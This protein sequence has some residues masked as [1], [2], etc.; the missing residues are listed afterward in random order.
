LQ[1]N[2]T[3]G[4]HA[5]RHQQESSMNFRSDINGLRA[6]AVLAVILFHFNPAWLPGGFAGVDVFFVISGYLMTAIIY[7]GLEQRNL[8]ILQFYLARGKRIIPALL[9]P[10]L[11]L[12]GLG[13]LFLLP[14][15]YLAVGKHVAA[16]LTFISNM[17]YWQESSYF[18]AASHEKWLLHTWSLSVEWQFYM[19]Y[20]VVMALLARLLGMKSL[21]WLLLAGAVLGYGGALYA[22][23]RWPD[24]AFFLL[25][26]RAWE[27]MLGGV[28]LLFPL[29]LTAGRRRALELGGA[30]LIAVSY[31]ACSESDAWPG[32]MALMPVLGAYALIAANRQESA[33]TGNRFAQWVGNI[34]YSLY[35]WHWPVVVLFSYLGLIGEPP[36]QLLGIAVSL[37]L[38]QA[39]YQLVEQ[40]MKAYRGGSGMR[41]WLSGSGALAGAA[42]VV[43]LLHGVVTP[44][45][46]ISVSDKAGFVARYEADHVQLRDAHWIYKCDVAMNIERRGTPQTDPV[47]TTRQGA[48]EGGVFLWGD[49]HA[50]ALSY[51]LRSA[52]PAGTPFYQ[53]TSSGC[54]PS[55]RHDVKLKGHFK[56]ACNYASDLAQQAIARLKPTT[57]ILGQRQ[58]HEKTDWEEMARQLKQAGV[59]QVI[60]AGPMPQWQPSLPVVMVNRHWN[61][62]AAYI[63]DA[64]LDER[65]LH[66]NEIMKQRAV[67][68]SYVYLSLTDRL[69]QGDSCLAQLPQSQGLL[70][71]DYGHLSQAGSLYVVRNVLLPAL[72][73]HHSALQVAINPR[74]R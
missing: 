54:R 63:K 65:S 33:L 39:S 34:S 19:I 28:A 35:I 72:A 38:A 48:A 31:V 20:P 49:S 40:R 10:C 17:V 60:V 44:W 9:P 15:E 27:M 47:C 7:R 66:T 45:R 30:A 2:S 5:A 61:S 16:S 74:S 6:L 46:P 67:G 1:H 21:R 57:V 70:V 58:D 59:Q 56:M 52:L 43:F 25:P 11:L 41:V 50:E 13:W 29:T 73:P 32:Y 42:G 26:A 12:L 4:A 64:A 53:V 22:S 37:L 3:A 18:A 68:S 36:Y 51:G 24:A 69:C 62:S 8:G 14:L 55:L 71:V 23:Y